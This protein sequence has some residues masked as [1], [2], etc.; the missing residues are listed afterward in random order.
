MKK[1]YEESNVR[2]FIKAL[3]WRLFATAT[4]MIIVYWITGE[5]AIAK[6]IGILEFA[7]KI[8]IY[9]L[10]ERIWNIFKFGK[11]RV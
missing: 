5:L 11:V 6:K 7:S 8:A 2:S 3:S 4:T 9:Y 1:K 10:H